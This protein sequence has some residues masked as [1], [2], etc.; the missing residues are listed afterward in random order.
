MK[1]ATLPTKKA[2][3]DAVLT[4]RIDPR[5]KKFWEDSI[6]KLGAED[7]SSYIRRAVDRSI[8]QDVRSLD[9]KWQAFLEAIQK[10]ANEFLGHGL[11]DDLKN[12]IGS[13]NLSRK[14]SL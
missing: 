10:S 5:Q 7:L 2:S 1:T 8:G 14:K 9:P 6:E 4:I 11:S 13:V 12:R 3:K